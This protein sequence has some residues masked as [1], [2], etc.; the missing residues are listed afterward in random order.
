MRTSPTHPTM[1]VR[2]FLRSIQKYGLRGA[3]SHAFARIIRSLR[4]YG[5]RGSVFRAF[6][7]A[8]PPPRKPA[9]PPHPFDLLHGT[10]TGGWITWDE[11]AAST[12]SSF[13]VVASL[14][15]APSAL[16]QAIEHLPCKLEELTFVD[17]GSGKGRA[18]IVAAQFPFRRIIGVELSSDICRIAETNIATNP[19]WG[20]RTSILN[21]NAATVVYPEAPLLIFM[22]HPFFAP[23]LR[24]VLA[25]LERQLRRSPRETWLLYAD[26]PHYSR[27]LNK[28]PFLREISETSYKLSAEDA[29]AQMTGQAQ[30]SFTL[31]S[32]DLSC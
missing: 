30:L 19:E 32:V 8:P 3:L 9:P 15:I 12:P 20:A 17:I 1:L 24:K 18:M 31:Y 27:V 29:A 16:A 21:Q 25:N 5:L 4:N 22:Y 23:V 28:F 11:L 6:R 2:R 14:G 10:D 26:N 13:Y 7:K